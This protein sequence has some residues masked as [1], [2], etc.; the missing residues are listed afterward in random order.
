MN[1]ARTGRDRLFRKPPQYSRKPT[2]LNSSKLTAAARQVH[3]YRAKTLQEAFQL[4][5]RDLGREATVLE[6]KQVW[7]GLWGGLC[8]ERQFEVRAT[9]SAP[10]AAP[11]PA[12]DGRRTSTTPQEKSGDRMPIRPRGTGT[13]DMRDMLRENLLRFGDASYELTSWS[14]TSHETSHRRPISDAELSEFSRLLELGYPEN[15]ARELIQIAAKNCSPK[16]EIQADELRQNLEQELLAGI[17]LSG[18]TKIKKNTPTVVALI[19]PTGVG[20][21]TTIAKLAADYRLQQ[22]LGVGLV[23]IDTFRMAA[24]EQLRAYAEIM[25]LPMEVVSNPSEMRRARSRLGSCD[26]VLIDTAG[27]NPQAETNTRELQAAIEAAQVDEA[28]LVLSA[29]M[30][31]TSLRKTLDRFQGL[32][33]TAIVLSKA[34]EAVGLGPF[35]AAIRNQRIPLSYITH[36]QS[37][38]DDITPASSSILKK[39][40]LQSSWE[41]A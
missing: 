39:I 24:V 9:T 38:P 17:P 34:D 27:C 16:R 15:L 37:V 2:D 19:G 18:M 20:K 33:L 7:D 22:N 26:L 12:I 13:S 28:H 31:L 30:S 10:G 23:T 3:H 35:F 25:D 8:G 21:T 11:S 5:R 6:T 29:T 14:G 41:N 4:V 40:L 32:G 36:G 1:Q